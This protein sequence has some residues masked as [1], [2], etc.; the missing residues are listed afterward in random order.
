[1]F[2]IYLIAIARYQ[3]RLNTEEL[4][5]NPIY[6][7]C[8]NRFLEQNSHVETFLNSAIHLLKTFFRRNSY[9]AI[10]LKKTE[11]LLFR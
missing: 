10:T 8:F 7:I 6:K 5:I 11:M 4:Y 9:E 1:M 3:L 2:N